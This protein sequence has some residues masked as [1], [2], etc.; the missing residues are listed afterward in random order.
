MDEIK[1][2]QIDRHKSDI[3]VMEHVI[4]GWYP[5]MRYPA[6]PRGH[7]NDQGSSRRSGGQ[8]PSHSRPKLRHK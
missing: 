2:G 1:K 7:A 5:H 6:E 8:K 4:N 3:D